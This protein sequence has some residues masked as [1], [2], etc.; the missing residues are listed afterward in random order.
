[1]GWVKAQT[2]AASTPFNRPLPKEV[3]NL[4]ARLLF[5]KLKNV[6]ALLRIRARPFM[7]A[8]VATSQEASRL[9]NHSSPLLT[10]NF[11]FFNL[12]FGIFYT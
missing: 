11:G 9:D 1:M 12:L 6:T 5:R 4:A 10:K 2:Y 3:I 7:L 8:N